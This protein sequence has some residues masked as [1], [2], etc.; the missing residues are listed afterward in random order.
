MT[1]GS[2]KSEASTGDGWDANWT[3]NFL[4]LRGKDYQPDAM[5]ESTKCFLKSKRSYLVKCMQY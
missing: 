3:Q 5:C 2:L 4:A 1:V